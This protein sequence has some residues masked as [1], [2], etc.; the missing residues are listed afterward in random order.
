MATID[1][2]RIAVFVRVVESGSFTAAAKL[3]ELPVSSVSRSVA[4][5]EEELGVRLLHRTTRKLALTDAGHEFFQ[6]MQ[7]VV[8]ETDAATRAVTG[9]AQVPR[10]VVRLTAPPNLDGLAQ[11]CAKIARRYP[12]VQLEVRLTNRVIDLVEEGIDLAVRGGTLED[13]TLVARKVGDSNLFLFATPA[14]LEKGGKPRAVRDLIGHPCLR[15]GGKEGKLP[16]RFKG[17]QG[18]ES[19]AV[20]GPFTCDDMLTLREVTLAGIGIGLLPSNVAGAAVKAGKL[21][22]VLPSYG[23]VGGGLYVVWPSQRLV[24][25]RVVAVR[26]LLIAELTKVHA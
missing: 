1:L 6:R 21:V 18:Y 22:R 15:Y 3:L 4:N 23:I 2:N 24:P 25:A 10:G 11:A 8:A 26:E 16:W 13:S 14:Y 17:P 7:V 19:V 9:D 12:Q 5:L 20:S